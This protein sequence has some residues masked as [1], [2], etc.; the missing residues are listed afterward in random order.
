MINSW[1]T[2]AFWVTMTTTLVAIV[3]AVIG[4]IAG[5]AIK[6][7]VK[8]VIAVVVITVVAGVAAAVPALIAE[9]VTDGT[10]KA[11]PSI[12]AMLDNATAPVTWPEASGFT[13]HSAELSGAFLLGGM[14]DIVPPA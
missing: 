10:A 13:L 2:I 3:G 5:P 11:L 14:I 6:E 8:S 12:G 1:S 4:A 9:V 7:I